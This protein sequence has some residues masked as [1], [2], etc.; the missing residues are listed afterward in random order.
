VA[1]TLWAV[2]STSD[3]GLHGSFEAP[4]PPTSFDMLA[5]L[6]SISMGGLERSDLARTQPAFHPAI[7]VQWHQVYDRVQCL[8]REVSQSLL[9]PPAC[10]AW[11]MQHQ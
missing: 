2:R 5:Q 7:E 6:P 8:V 11:G 4:A 3:S 10:R 9:A 1:V